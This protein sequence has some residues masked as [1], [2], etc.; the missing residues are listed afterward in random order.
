ML[1]LRRRLEEFGGRY[2]DNE[3]RVS[4]MWEGRTDLDLHCT[5][6]H[7]EHLCYRSKKS[8]YTD[9]YLDLDMNGLDQSS[10]K[11]VEN[12]RWASEAPEGV[13]KFYV[14]NYSEKVNRD[15]TPFKAEL[16]IGGKVYHFDGERLKNGNKEIVFEFEYK[17]GQEPRFI[18]G[19]HTSSAVEAWGVE[20]V[21]L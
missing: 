6:P 9:G 16:E 7:G 12:M 20:L 13:Y 21:N 1:Q 10:D 15:G 5:T 8:R 4:L 19:G 3:I 2:E 14:H 11:P 17:R 18:R